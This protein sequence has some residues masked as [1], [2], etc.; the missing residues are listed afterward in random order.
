MANRDADRKSEMK[1][2]AALIALLILG[3]ASTPPEDDVRDAVNHYNKRVLAM[4][5]A[6]I[7]EMYAPD[8]EMRLP[9]SVIRGRDEIA[10]YLRT[11]D[12]KF[13]LIENDTH[14][15]AIEVHGDTA[16]VTSTF[17]QR[18]LII[19]SSQIV[20]PHG[21]LH[22]EWVRGPDKKWRIKWMSTQ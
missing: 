12:G 2:R 19:E 5:A 21:T 20:E 11:F 18:T 7:A 22:S 13:R 10:K 8:G 15:N 14:I 9:N 3:C 6:G 1:T 17:R 4:D 16:G